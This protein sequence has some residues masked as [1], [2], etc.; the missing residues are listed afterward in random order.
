MLTMKYLGIKLLKVK[1]NIR[2]QNHNDRFM[3]PYP[4]TN[5]STVPA[6][7]YKVFDWWKYS[8]DIIQYDYF[9]L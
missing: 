8:L 7:S 6:V 3:P 4:W 2:Y 1:L 9:I 5:V